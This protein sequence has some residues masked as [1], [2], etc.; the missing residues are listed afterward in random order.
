MT[1][2]LTISDSFEEKHKLSR[3]SEKLLEKQRRNKRK[4]KVFT[5]SKVPKDESVAEIER[6]PQPQ[7][8]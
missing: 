2:T 7:R 4:S 8:E 3:P 1:E 5:L 6:E